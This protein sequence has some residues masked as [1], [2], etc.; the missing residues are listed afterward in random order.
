MEDKQYLIKT[1]RKSFEDKI[2][3]GIMW[4]KFI[5]SVNGIKLAPR[6]LELLAFINYRGTISSTSSK[7]EFCKMFDSSNGTIT[8]MSARLL[9][10]KLLVKEKSKTKLHPSLRV[11]FDKDFVVRFYMDVKKET[12][13]S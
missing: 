6:E 11:D 10:M 8:N 12:N 7:E 3:A 9:K 13:A 2:Q 5:A 1:I 4:F